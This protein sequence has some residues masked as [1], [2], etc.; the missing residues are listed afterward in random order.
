METVKYCSLGV[1]SY[2]AFFTVYLLRIRMHRKASRNA[3]EIAACTYVRW[4]SRMAKREREEEFEVSEVAHL[5][6]S[7]NI[8]GVVKTLY[9][10]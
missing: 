3:I 6:S 4:R 9:L 8:K 5:S 7:A 2:T 10:L 1:F